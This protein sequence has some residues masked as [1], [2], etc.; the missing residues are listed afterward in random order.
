MS[1]QEPESE[2]R[3]GE[4]IEDSVRDD[5]GVNVNVAGSIS[6]TPD[7]KTRKFCEQELRE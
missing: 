6:D 5:L 7:T 1:E 4:N 2:D 3:L